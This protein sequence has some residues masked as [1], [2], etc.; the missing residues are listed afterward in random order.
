MPSLHARLMLMLMLMFMLMLMLIFML[1]SLLISTVFNGIINLDVDTY[2]LTVFLWRN[3]MMKQK[4]DGDKD[5]V[6]KKRGKA[7]SWVN[8]ENEK[9][10]GVLCYLLA[11]S[12]LCPRV[13]RLT[14]IERRCSGMKRNNH[15]IYKNTDEKKNYYQSWEHW[16]EL[17][18]FWS[19]STKYK[20]T[21]TK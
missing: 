1:L 18:A 9:M 10:S 14:K 4:T 2:T 11:R 3:W 20:N 21:N 12:I 7:I 5:V 16:F 8:C 13:L 17:P 19:L 15:E 6:E